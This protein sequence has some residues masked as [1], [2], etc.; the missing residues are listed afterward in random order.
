MITSRWS[1]EKRLFSEDE[2]IF[3]SEP[4]ALEQKVINTF[5]GVKSDR[6]TATLIVGV[7][8]FEVGRPCE[9]EEHAQWMRWMLA[10]AL[11]TF[12]KSEID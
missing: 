3:V 5:T 8:T 10:K 4:N 6:L 1:R 12:H 7:Q 2:E 9:T 11:I